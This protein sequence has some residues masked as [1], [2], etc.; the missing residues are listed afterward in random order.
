MMGIILEN[1]N[2]ISFFI[3]NKIFVYAYLSMS[4]LGGLFVLIK[5]ICFTQGKT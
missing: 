2:F 1:M 3:Q 4:I 5:G